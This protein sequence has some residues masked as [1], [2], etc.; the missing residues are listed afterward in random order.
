MASILT[1][2]ELQKAI[3]SVWD[4]TL[5]RYWEVTDVLLM[6]FE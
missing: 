5:Q 2:Q 6:D 1:E 4:E 3:D